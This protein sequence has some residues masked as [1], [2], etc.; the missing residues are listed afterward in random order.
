WAPEADRPP[1]GRIPPPVGNATSRRFLPASSSGSAPPPGSLLLRETERD[2]PDLAPGANRSPN[3]SPPAPNTVD[4]TS[5]RRRF[6]PRRRRLPREWASPVP[7]TN[8]G[9][10]RAFPPPSPG[11]VRIPPGDRHLGPTAERALPAS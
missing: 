8:R 11:E 9:I 3:Y 5:E 2:P 6:H 7:S 10:S 4:G 1:S